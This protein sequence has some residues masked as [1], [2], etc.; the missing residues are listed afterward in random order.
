M[1]VPFLMPL[2][3]GGFQQRGGVPTNG[4]FDGK[5]YIFKFRGKSHKVARLICETFNG[6][7]PFSDSIC[8]HSDEDSRNNLPSNL[9]WGTQKENLNA[10][11]FLAYCKGRVGESN[12]FIKGR[13]KP[14]AAEVDRANE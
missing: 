9:V 4:Y 5:R 3:H 13:K 8:M 6:P 2:P 11:G 1:V 12:P 10:P 7:P 14:R